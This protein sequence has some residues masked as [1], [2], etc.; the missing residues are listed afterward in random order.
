MT[1]FFLNGYEFSLQ[2]D[3]LD[4]LIDHIDKANH[5]RTCSYLTSFARYQFLH[6]TLVLTHWS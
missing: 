2:V 6:Q 5:K 4:M 3:K 1:E